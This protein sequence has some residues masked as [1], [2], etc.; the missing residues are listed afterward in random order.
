MGVLPRGVHVTYP[1]EIAVWGL[2]PPGQ[3]RPLAQWLRFTMLARLRPGV[4]VEQATAA[5]RTVP[6]LM[7]RSA[8]QGDWRVVAQ[9]IPRLGVGDPPGRRCGSVS[10]AVLLLLVTACLN[11]SGGGGSAPTRACCC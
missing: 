2:L 3:I 6:G 4:R 7:P 10:G 8:Q 9:P 1:E 5:L 11:A